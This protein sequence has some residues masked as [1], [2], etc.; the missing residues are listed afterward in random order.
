MATKQTTFTSAQVEAMLAKARAEA[1]AAAKAKYAKYA[2]PRPGEAA[3]LVAVTQEDRQ[4]P[5]YI[6]VNLWADEAVGLWE[7]LHEGGFRDT[8]DATSPA[9]MA[10]VVLTR[11][12]SREAAKHGFDVPAE[13]RKNVNPTC[14]R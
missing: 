9:E 2:N 12:L 3:P 4:N 14:G 1:E 8:P 13:V 6:R 7:A 10:Y 5:A 11:V